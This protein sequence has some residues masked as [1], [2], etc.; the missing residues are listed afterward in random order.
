ME[1][2]TLSSIQFSS[3]S[4]SELEQKRKSISIAKQDIKSISLRYGPIV[5]RP[6][7]QAIVGLILILLGL[8]LGIYPLYWAVLYNNLP[9]IR[10]HYPTIAG[11]KVFAYA[12]P[13]VFIGAYLLQRLFIKRFYLLV[14]TNND[15]RK[16][17]FN[18]KLNLKEVRAFI[19]N[20][21][22]SFRYE[23]RVEDIC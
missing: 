11:I 5:E 17:I 7:A 14:L 1:S 21:N 8:Y 12:L 15:K 16:L 19:T 2:M 22:G 23:V 13:L 18:D 10:D 20:C 3:D 6:T 9:S 4:V